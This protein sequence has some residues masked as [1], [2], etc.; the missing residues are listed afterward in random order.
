MSQASALVSFLLT[1]PMGRVPRSHQTS[2]GASEGRKAGNQGAI[3]DSG[4]EG[5]GKLGK[6]GEGAFPTCQGQ[7]LILKVK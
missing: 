4:Q 5:D 7:P 1:E 2:S 6:R 3:L